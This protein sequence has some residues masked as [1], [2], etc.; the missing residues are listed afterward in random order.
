MKHRY[1]KRIAALVLVGLMTIS[2]LSTVFADG[3][4]PEKEYDEAI[5]VIHTNDV[6]GHI[7]VEPYVK[8]LADQM[9]ASGDYSLVL[10]VSAG[11]V[12]DGGKAV[13]GYYKGELIP[14]LEDQIYDVIVPGNNDFP[15]GLAQNILL[16]S[17]YENTKTICANGFANEDVDMAAYAAQYQAAIGNADFA[18]LYDKVKLNKDGTLDVSGLNLTTV[19]KDASPWDKTTVVTTSKGTKLGLFGLSCTGGQQA[20]FLHSNGTVAE[21]KAAVASLKGEGANVIIGVAHTGWM[22]EKSKEPAPAN[23]TNSWAL[24]NEIQEMDAIIDSHTHS[25]IGD[26]KGCYVGGNKVLINQAACFGDCIG[27]MYFYLKD[28]KVID[29]NADVI[30]G[31][32]LEKITPDKKISK[33]VKSDLARI[34]KIAGPSLVKT[35]YFLNGERISAG[36]EGG[37]IRGNETNLGDFITDV[38]LNAASEK[39]GT[40]YDFT[41][42]PGYWLRSSIDKDADITKIEIASVIGMPTKLVEQDY[43]AKDIVNLVTGSLQVVYPQAENITFYQYSGLYITYTNDNGVGTPVTIKVGDKLIYDANRGGIVVDA[44]WTAKGVRTLHADAGEYTGDDSKTICEDQAAVQEMVRDYL[45][46]HEAGKDYVFYPNKVAPAGRVVEVDKTASKAPAED[47]S[48]LV[49]VSINDLNIRTGAGTDT[50]KT[51]MHVP[52]GIYTI[53]EVVEGKGSSAG[54]GKLKSGLG[55]ISLDYVN[56]L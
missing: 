25:I 49:K 24:A 34:Q 56:K 17:L 28:G 4:S 9:K 23:D 8:G 12:Y 6:H 31:D 15:G 47:S 36:N 3:Q 39:R 50:A 44:S 55:Y 14:A 5:A 19:A 10:T 52:A 18:E 48:F 22:G 13:A 27:V 37:T 32:D 40:K 45:S 21:A 35:P 43:S 11:D 46:K 30:R 54:W 29:K 53:V 41:F 38:I 20:G 1:P 7:E 26:G 33:M 42:F 16:T 2:T 51:G